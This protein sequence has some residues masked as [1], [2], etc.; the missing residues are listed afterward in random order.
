MIR[1]I[2]P[3]NVIDIIVVVSVSITFL[4][5]KNERLQISPD[6]SGYAV[7]VAWQLCSGKRHLSGKRDRNIYFD[8][9]SASKKR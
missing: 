4:S 6:C 9:R 7:F 3:Q 5:T 8:R 2:K 1:L